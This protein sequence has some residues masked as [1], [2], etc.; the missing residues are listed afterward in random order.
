MGL[1][2]GMWNCN[3]CEWDKET[4]QHIVCDCEILPP[5]Q[6]ILV[7]EGMAFSTSELIAAN[8]P[9][10]YPNLIPVA[11]RIKPPSKRLVNGHYFH[12]EIKSDLISEIVR[13]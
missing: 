4:V 6:S 8:Y 5:R 11:T 12:D 2:N 10:F 3:L 9:F 13:H 7:A 1:Y